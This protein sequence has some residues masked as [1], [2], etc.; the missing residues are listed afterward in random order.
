MIAGMSTHLLFVT[1]FLGLV[2][3]PQPVEVK[4]DDA[5]RAVDFVLDGRTVATLRGAPWRTVIDLGPAVVP[6]Q[7]TAIAYD[8]RGDELGRQTQFVNL[9]RP[10]AEASI[11]LGDRTAEVRWQHLTAE[12]PDRIRL[13]LDRRPLAL[14]RNHRAVLPDVDRKA[15][16]ILSAEV[17]FR[18]GVLAQKELVFG[19]LYAD[20][21]P[22]ELSGVLVTMRKDDPTVAD[23]QCLGARVAAL[24]R[25]ESLVMFVR[26]EDADGMAA[27]L[28]AVREK[29]RRLDLGPA[30]IRFVRPVAARVPVGRETVSEVFDQ[31]EILDPEKGMESLLMIAG[32]ARG[33]GPQRLA[34]AVAVAGVRA[35]E[36]AR[37]RAVVL[38]LG[39][40]V[41]DA[42]R[43]DAAAIRRYLASV[44]VP[45]YVWSVAGGPGG[46]WGAAEDIATVDGLHAA[47]E[48]LRSALERQRIAWLATDPISALRVEAASE[49]AVAPV[50]HR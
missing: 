33:G 27:P 24:E 48:R 15:V 26:D 4:V 18:D 30:T 12:K 25:P 16:H 39:R 3:G 7:L 47:V 40:D 49:C 5:V 2:A 32:S 13:M 45:L 20:E 41:H 11:I 34:D 38:I 29:Q 28:S 22:A 44:G 46:R 6:Q 19:G 1:L 36:G 23:A 21:M 50:A 14:D 9:A 43:H 17:R 42:S 35:L 31:T 10:V 8:A 37:R